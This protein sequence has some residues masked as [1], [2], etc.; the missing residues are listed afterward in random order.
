MVLKFKQL[1]IA[2]L[3]DLS[4]HKTVKTKNPTIR[5]QT[6]L[7]DFKTIAAKMGVK[8]DML[9]FHWRKGK[10]MNPTFFEKI[11]NTFNLKL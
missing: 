7:L 1:E 11:L 8:E 9:R 3:S 2:L 5:Y 4:L 6:S 10:N